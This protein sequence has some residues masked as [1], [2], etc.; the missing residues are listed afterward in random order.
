MRNLSNLAERCKHRR[1]L[2]K[3]TQIG[4]AQKCGISSVSIHLIEKGDTT[5]PK[6]ETLLSLARALKCS[7][8]W[9]MYGEHNDN[10]E[11]ETPADRG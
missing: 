5:S 2:L 7:A 3:L 6:A 11:K 4:L 1:E 8:E 10:E 9:L